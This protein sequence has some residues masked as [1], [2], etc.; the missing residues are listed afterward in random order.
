MPGSNLRLT[1]QGLTW[2][3]FWSV[4]MATHKLDKTQWK[5]FFDGLS[6]VLGPKR[7][8]IEVLSLGLG[9]QVAAE[10]LPLVGLVY[11]PRDD[12]VEVALDGL[13][14]LVKQPREIYVVEEE[15]GELLAIEVVTADGVRQIIRL[16]D[17][18]ALP[19]PQH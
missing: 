12:M 4:K 8:E 19:A 16:K 17:P 15:A 9:D 11:D 1:L 6:E 13:Y 7:V 3:T 18:L 10:W 14:H 5:A 2:V